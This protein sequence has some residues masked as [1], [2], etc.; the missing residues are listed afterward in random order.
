MAE[1]NIGLMEAIEIAMEAEKKANK[2]YVDAAKKVASGQGKNL[3][4]QLAD[5][6]QNHYD[7]LNELKNSLS[8]QGKFIKYEG[9]KFSPFKASSEIS[10]TIEPNKD[11]VLDILSMAIEAETKA[12]EHYKKMAGE[13]ADRDGKE[14]FEKLAEEETMHRRILNDE[15][16]NIANKGGM[17]VWGE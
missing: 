3:L 17:W 12:H 7:K 6:E 15:F 5:F 1:K 16:Y 9:T 11:E 13:T 2:F 8:K 4:K 10:G 14:M